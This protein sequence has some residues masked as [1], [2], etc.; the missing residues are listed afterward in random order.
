VSLEELYNNTRFFP[1]NDDILIR[2]PRND[3]SLL[4]IIPASS[5]NFSMQG[6]IQI[7]AKMIELDTLEIPSVDDYG[8]PRM[9]H[10]CNEKDLEKIFKSITGVGKDNVNAVLEVYS[11]GFL[12][13]ATAG[14]VVQ[15][16]QLGKFNLGDESLSSITLS[17][18]NLDAWKKLQ[19]KKGVC[20]LSYYD[21]KDKP[22]KV[23][24]R[25]SLG[26]TAVITWFV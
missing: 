26:S 20:I 23:T 8:N 16:Y 1:K 24:M 15:T 10:N 14:S 17:K 22:F 3:P 25:R 4:N 19:I 18:D 5:T 2:I 13:R 6:V 21:V 7:R 11:E 9:T 12:I